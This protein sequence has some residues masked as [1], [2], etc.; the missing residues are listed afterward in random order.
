MTITRT[1]YLE[2][3]SAHDM[4]VVY[5]YCKNVGKFRNYNTFIS[6]IKSE[7]YDELL[8]H[9][10]QHPIKYYLKLEATYNQTH[11][12]NSSENKAFKPQ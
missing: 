1:P 3:H 2:I 10:Q 4:K 11:A 12:K 5:Y 7:F 9:V 8:H 6:H